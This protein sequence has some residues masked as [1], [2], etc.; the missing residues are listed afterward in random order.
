MRNILLIVF[1]CVLTLAVHASDS[2]SVQIG[3]VYPNQLGECQISIYFTQE[4]ADYSITIEKTDGTFEAVDIDV[5]AFWV[6]VDE[7]FGDGISGYVAGSSWGVD[8]TLEGLPPGTYR[9]YMSGS[10][11]PGYDDLSIDEADVVVYDF[12]NYWP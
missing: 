8:I 1:S 4:H 7:D 6:D 2:V 5:D 10:S 11:W 3:T 12:S 9:C